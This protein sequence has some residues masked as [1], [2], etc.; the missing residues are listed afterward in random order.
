MF[1]IKI[2]RINFPYLLFFLMCKC[3]YIPMYK[4]QCKLITVLKIFFMC[5]HQNKS[6]YLSCISIGEIISSIE[7]WRGTTQ[8]DCNRTVILIYFMSLSCKIYKAERLNNGSKIYINCM[9]T[10]TMPLLVSITIHCVVHVFK[11]IC[12]VNR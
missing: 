8:S 11:S 3:I 9:R 6:S 10:E 12:N 2:V 7:I 4:S 5:N 1:Q